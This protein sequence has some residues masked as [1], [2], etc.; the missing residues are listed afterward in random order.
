M[1]TR[2]KKDNRFVDLSGYS[3]ALSVAWSYLTGTVPHSAGMQGAVV[4]L[5]IDTLR[6]NPFM[7][8]NYVLKV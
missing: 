2:K 3:C 8:V 4:E 6:M 7:P 1:I 5:Q